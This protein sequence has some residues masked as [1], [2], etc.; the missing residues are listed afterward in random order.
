MY[1]KI[2]DILTDK[3]FDVYPLGKH[4][5]NCTKPF[6]VIKEYLPAKTTNKSLVR[7]TFD[8]FPFCPL[9]RYSQVMTYITNLQA[10][11]GDVKEIQCISD[12]SPIMIDNDKQ[13]YT[14]RISYQNLRRR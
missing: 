6:V 4:S 3:G 9:A 13:A 8:I 7:Q 14:T 11:L 2:A 12:S 5:G 1:S 10:V